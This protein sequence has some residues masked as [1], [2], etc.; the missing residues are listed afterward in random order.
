[1]RSFS[2]RRTP[3][4]ANRQGQESNRTLTLPFWSGIRKRKISGHYLPHA[5]GLR[6]FAEIR[7]LLEG[8]QV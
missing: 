5:E 2:K 1:M 6:R 8:G 7:R 3:A 4:G